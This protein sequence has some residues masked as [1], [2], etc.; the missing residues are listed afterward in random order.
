M[1]SNIGPHKEIIENTDAGVIF[2]ETNVDDLCSSIKRTTTWNIKEMAKIAREVA[3]KNFGIRSLASKYET[4]YRSVNC[5][6]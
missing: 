4:I 5:Q 2:D 3:V 6:R 1:L